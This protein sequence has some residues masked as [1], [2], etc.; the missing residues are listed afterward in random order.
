MR[1]TFDLLFGPINEYGRGQCLS[2]SLNVGRDIFLQFPEIFFE[3]LVFITVII[4]VGGVRSKKIYN[5]S[6]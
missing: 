2:N 5:G 6:P 3:F 4:I 1:F